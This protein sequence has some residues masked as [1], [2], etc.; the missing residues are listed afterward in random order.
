MTSV[1]LLSSKK[2][3]RENADERLIKMLSEKY[4]R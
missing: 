2:M 4:L 3:I 1:K